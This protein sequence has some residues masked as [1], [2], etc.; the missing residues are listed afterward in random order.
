MVKF[1]NNKLK[2]EVVELLKFCK[3]NGIE[4]EFYQIEDWDNDTENLITIDYDEE[5]EFCLPRDDDYF[6]F[7]LRD[8]IDIKEDVLNSKLNG[9]IYR[10][11]NKFIMRV[12]SSEI[13]YESLIEEKDTKFTYKGKTYYVDLIQNCAEYS[14][15]VAI[16]G[17]YSKY[18][19]PTLPEDL[20]IYIYCKDGIDKNIDAIVQRYIFE[21][22]SIFNIQLFE[23]PRPEFVDDFDEDDSRYGNKRIIDM[24]IDDNLTEIISI[25]NQASNIESIES[26]ILNYTRVIEYASQ[27]VI[28]KDLFE[29]VFNKLSSERVYSP[30]SDYI[31]ELEQIFKDNSKYSKD[32]EAIKVTVKQCCDAMNLKLHAPDFL[33]KINKLKVDSK[34]SE[35][36]EALEELARAISDT[37]NMFSHAKTNYTKKGMECPKEQLFKFGEC[38]KVVANQVIRW[39]ARQSNTYII[40]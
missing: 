22:D 10:S 28:K 11:K 5:F 31:L 18:L 25:F 29:S 37:R 35:Q 40:K 20:F 7:T 8:I 27:T 24:E 34:K 30:D 16:N 17:N 23:S 13:R 36:L 26:K 1:T 3:E 33:K 39:Y 2:E 21:V 15:S 19:P 6:S 38:I 12:E 4:H 32:S 9:H 14:I